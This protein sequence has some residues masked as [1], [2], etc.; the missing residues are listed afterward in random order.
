MFTRSQPSAAA[1]SSAFRIA[2]VRGEAASL[3]EDAVAAQRH[4]RR[5]PAHA[6][7]PAAAAPAARGDD[8]G[9]VRA[10]ARAV[11]APVAGPLALHRV[12]AAAHQQIG[13]VADAG[14]DHADRDAAAGREP[15]RAVEM[16]E[17]VARGEVERRERHL[18]RGARAHVAPERAPQAERRVDVEP[19]D[20][21]RRGREA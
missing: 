19:L 16:A 8:S 9:D 5:E 20:R 7:R 12:L 3:A 17:R 13:M 10:V 2:E 21:P 1:R 14:V 11:V 6:E 18:D 4:G 15:R